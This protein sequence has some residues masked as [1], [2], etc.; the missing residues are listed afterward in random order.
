M[1]TGGFGTTIDLTTGTPRQWYIGRD[2]IKRWADNDQ[3][4]GTEPSPPPCQTGGAN[5]DPHQR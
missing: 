2:G 1:I 3:P 4:T 5:E